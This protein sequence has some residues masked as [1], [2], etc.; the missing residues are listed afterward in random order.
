VAVGLCD[1][2]TDLGWSAWMGRG[3]AAGGFEQV[4]PVLLAVPACGQVQGDVAAAVTG[5]AG[6]DVDEVT[7]QRGATC[8]GA[9]EAGQGPGGA[10]Q[11]MADRRQGQPGGVGGK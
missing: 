3:R 6:G 2:V 7:A 5:G 4:H 1:A 10:Q 8:S 11:V 9:G